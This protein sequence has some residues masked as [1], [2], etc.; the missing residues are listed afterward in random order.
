MNRDY[1]MSRD[2]QTPSFL[3]RAVVRVV[4][5]TLTICTIAGAGYAVM[6][7]TNVIN[8]RANAAAPAAVA[9]LTPVSVT[10]LSIETGFSVAREF[11]GQF[12]AAQSA[13]LSFEFGGLVAE[14]LVDEG[15]TVERGQIIARLD[16]AL[17]EADL[18]R[19]E[20][21]REAL[22]ARL[23]FAKLSVDRREA[24]N[25]RGFAPTEALD[26]A[27]FDRDELAARIAETDATIDSTRIR[28][29]KSVLIAPFDGR[30]S[31]R[32][33]DTG[34]TVGGG[35]QIVQLLEDTT[36][37]LRV[38]LP[39]W[40][41]V[42]TLKDARIS[43]NEREVPATLHRL[44][45]DIDPV[46]RTRTA[47]FTAGMDLAPAYGETAQLTADRRI[48]AAG[49]W[50]PLRAL[51]EGAPGVWTVLIVDNDDI[52]RPAAVEVLHST[53]DR[54]YVTGTFEDGARL[55]DSGPQRV[56]PGQ[57]VRVNGAE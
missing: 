15:S 7:G 38:G 55:I 29:E 40:L 42:D 6:V 56:T 16:T 35:Q 10:P 44:R 36:P 28:I 26:Q 45:P 2:D 21:S 48:A 17:L 1:V 32:A 3:R 8:A 14:I 54:A 33:V 41:D 9:T 49:A 25:E 53:T 19:F 11:T 22:E 39:V 34:A 37:L 24:L 5:I 47:L 4:T 18:R 31:L 23:S 50:V 13:D 12:E 52:V 30:I 57:Q 46:T 27:R 43:L 20:A 51:R